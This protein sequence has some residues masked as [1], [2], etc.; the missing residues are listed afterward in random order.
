MK[1]SYV[2]IGLIFF[3]SFIFAQK[4]I[5]TKSKA[6]KLTT[7]PEFVRGIPP[8]LQLGLD[9]KDKNDNKILE[10]EE[11]AELILKITNEGK[12]SA[13]GLL[14]KVDGE[15]EDPSLIIQDGLEVPFIFPNQTL[16]IPIHISA[17]KNIQT[18]EH[19]L[20]ISITEHF[21]YDMDPAYLIFNTYELQK[22]NLV[23]SGLDI[24]D[25]GEGTGAITED[26]QLQAGEMIKLKLVVQNIGQN[27]ASNTKFQ[28]LSTDENIYVDDNSGDIG[29]INS[30]EVKEFWVT[31]SPNKRVLTKDKL[32]LYLALKND[33][34]FGELN[35]Y[36]LPIILNQKPPE[37]EI[38]EVESD[39]QG[40]IKEIARFEY[41]SNRITAA[42][43][44]LIDINQVP[45]S[46]TNRPNS[47]A[48]IIG[49]EKYEYFAP[50]PYAKN[51][52]NLMKNYFKNVIG[53]EN[54][55][56]YTNEE[57]SGYFFENKFNPDY[58][59]LKNAVIKDSSDVFIYYSGHGLPSKNGQRVYLLPSDGRTEAL[60]TQG[61][62]L[63][64]LYKSLHSLHAKSVTLFMDACFSGVSRSSIN[65]SKQNLIAMKGIAIKPQISQPWETDPNFSVFAS[66]D[67]NETS[68]GYDKSK[69]GL[70]TYYLCA[71]LKGEADQNEDN[72]ISYGE[73]AEYI[74]SNVKEMSTKFLGVQSPQFNGNRDIILGEY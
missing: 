27:I 6:I 11:S 22:P 73:L 35:N 7:S 13:Q 61:F 28:V 2:L 17:K 23:F 10:A 41:N 60:E 14:I 18:K 31:V 51:D 53:V 67:F 54:V 56:L 1:K 46:K 9:F 32:P 62:D 12:G 52:A 70:F 19:K 47:I 63:N 69:T 44:N 68:L 72:K 20:K 39:I 5:S 29:I 43:S 59:E 24:V 42:T 4:K 64:Q 30:G 25:S 48:I 57:V 36:Q 26:G 8:Y 74:S 34:K 66:S 49:I 40:F 38:V 33:E 55:Y 21:G 71:G 37:T 16:E 50:A 15:I 58:G 3:T 45:P 65:Y